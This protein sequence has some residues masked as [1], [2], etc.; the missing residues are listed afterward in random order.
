MRKKYLFIIGGL[1]LFLFCFY[2][3]GSAF[4]PGSYPYAEHY[5]LNYPEKSV[6]E[7]AEIV[8]EQNVYLH[9]GEGWEDKDTT[10]HWHHIYFNFH[11][12]MLLTWTRPNGK[13]STTF[14]FVRMQDENSE[15]KNIN[16]DF[17]YFENRKL[18]KVLEEEI[19][20]RIKIEL[21]KKHK[22]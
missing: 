9:I 3:L 19:L 11:N 17:G 21:E 8:R 22:G 4:A 20:A 7:A 14:A 5:E 1:L 16:N 12:R 18:K 2:K 13:N 6:I 10:D 15:W